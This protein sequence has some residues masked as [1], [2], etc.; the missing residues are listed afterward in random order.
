P[1]Y[2]EFHRMDMHNRSRHGMLMT[3]VLR[4]MLGD[5]L[6]SGLHDEA[7]DVLRLPLP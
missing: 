7:L 2:R 4:G 1:W 5:G 6:T 3:S